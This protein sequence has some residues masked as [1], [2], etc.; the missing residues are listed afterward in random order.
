MEQQHA[1]LQRSI[2]FQTA[3]PEPE[4]YSRL[5]TK[6]LECTVRYPVEPSRAASTDQ[7]MLLAIRQAQSKAPPLE[8]VDGPVLDTAPG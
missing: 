4:V 2:D 5:T 6:G 7:K 8:V 1:A 3:M